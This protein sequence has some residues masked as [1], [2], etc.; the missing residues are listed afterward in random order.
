MQPTTQSATSSG[1]SAAVGGLERV[2]TKCTSPASL[3]V[4]KYYTL[5]HRFIVFPVSLVL[6]LTVIAKKA[7][8]PLVPSI[9]A[10]PF[11]TST[12]EQ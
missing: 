12:I 5:G 2:A 4:S 8:L 6:S 11:E 10:D 7:F 3:F 9:L 1:T